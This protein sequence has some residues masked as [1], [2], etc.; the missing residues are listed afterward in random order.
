[1][2]DS[3]ITTHYAK[4]IFNLAIETNNIKS[5]KNDI[6]LLYKVS[7]EVD[8]F[9]EVLLSPI[10]KVSKKQEIF[11]KLFVNDVD[12]TTISFL[13]LITKNRR[14]SYL[15]QMCLDFLTQY[16]LLYNIKQVEITTTKK[17]TEDF[18]QNLISIIKN[19]Y[20][21]DVDLNEKVDENIIGGFILTIED[22][23]LDASISTK[24]KNIEKE[25]KS[26]V[27]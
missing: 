14:E 12:K 4:A 13:N 2:N 24:L 6:E 19:T 5:I 1:M 26:S 25:L 27:N 18:K 22:K 15:K 10:I 3:K 23:R 11:Y 16:R 17:L 9:K 20:K 21:S 8:L 7:N